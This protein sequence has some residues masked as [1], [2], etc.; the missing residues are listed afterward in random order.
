MSGYYLF[1]MKKTLLKFLLITLTLFCLRTES[2]AQNVIYSDT[3]VVSQSYCPGSSQYD[4]WGTFRAALDTASNQFLKVTV[5]GTFNT[6]GRA[7]TNKY[8]V[9]KIAA[10]LKAGTAASYTCDG[11]TWSVGASSACYSN[12]C[13]TGA[14]SVEL[15]VDGTTCNCVTPGYSFRPGITNSNWGGINTGTCGGATQRM[16]VEF[17][18]ISKPND[19]GVAGLNT[20]N[21]CS[22][23]QDITAKISN[24]G[25]T[26]IDSF[27]VYWSV[28][29][30]LQTPRYISSNLGSGKDTSILL[31]TAFSFTNNTTYKFKFWTSRPNGLVDSV[32]LNDTLATTVNFFGNPP[33][34]TTTS[35]IQCG[36]GRPRLSAT[37]GVSTDTIMWYT[38]PTGGSSIGMGSS[39]LG[40][41]IRATT[42]FYAQA[43]RFAAKSVLSNGLT[44]NISVS[45]NYAAYNGN[46][47]D[48]TPYSPVNI[49][50]M[51]FRIYNFT[52][53]TNYLLYYKAG[54]YNGFENNSTAWTAVNGG[55]GRVFTTGGKNYLKVSAKGLLLN[56]GQSYGFYFTIDP[57]T[58]GGNDIYMQ[59]AVN[60]GNADLSM[61]GGKYSYGLFGASGFGPTYTIDC[62]VFYSKACINNSRTPLVV[63]VK[64][65]PIGADVVKG[66]TFNGQ[67]RVGDMSTPDIATLGKTITYELAPPTGYANADHGS[68]WVVNN[69]VAKTR[70]GAIVPSTDYTVV[71]PSSAGNGSISY[72]PKATYLDSFITFSTNFS[73]LGPHFCDSTVQRTLVVAPT[74]FVNFK[75]P[76]SICL[77]DAILFDN[78]STISSGNASYTWY[79]GD[80]DT[81]DLQAPVHEY[82][83]PGVYQVKLKAKSSPWNVFHD[84]TIQLEV[85]E[86]PAAKFRA[87]NKCQGIAVSFQNQTTVGN[88]ALTYDWDFGDNTAHSTATN[89]THNYTN[90]GGYKVTLKASANGC[91]ATVTKNAY[92]FARPVAN[93]AAPLAPICAKSDVLMPNTS[94]IA[95]GSQGAFWRFGNGSS[96]TQFDGKHAYAA[97]GTYAVKL[98]AVSEFDCKDSITK[99]VVIK[100]TPNPAFAGNQFC[101]KIPT[102]FT[103]ST[104]EELPSPVY[105]WSFSDGVTSTLKNVVKTWPSEGPFSATLKA[106]YSN[107]C[108]ASL[109]KDFEVLIQPKADFDVLDICSGETAA[110]VN[111]SRGD[112]GGIVYN[113]DFGNGTFS[114]L[115]APIRLYTPTATTT[116][117]VALVASYPGACSDTIRKTITVSESP[118]S[119]FTSKDLGL[120]K[121]SFTPTNTTYSKYEWL[122]GEG[123]S[124]SL[125]SPTYQYLYSGNFN[126][127]LR[128]TN[129]AGCSNSITKKA[130]ATTSINNINN[131]NS[132]NIYPNPNAG[133]FTVSNA[134]GSSMKVEIYNVLGEKVYTKTTTEG[135][136][137][138]NLDENAKGIYLVKVTVNGVTSTSKITVTN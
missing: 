123:G 69:V 132:I 17:Q 4:K 135:S 85:G 18:K 126:V 28:N 86:L 1:N 3:F 82:L 124:S 109:T 6:T 110:F 30:N 32:G 44:G 89:P 105:N 39:I 97:S 119:N 35:F 9:R 45:F 75:F 111:K 127:T 122:F 5:K 84:T 72:A 43:I 56:P 23:S 128:T 61:T 107:G 67:F 74:P 103:N 115:Q 31:Q 29:G 42:T 133:S 121:V 63:T 90:P 20:L 27:R 108:S 51:T 19:M 64:P 37:T 58:G 98:L 136:L 70:F 33:A 93:F 112:K 77:G 21:F 10:A 26:K 50:S 73:D 88:G 11:F 106:S 94:T 95:L 8:T 114:T 34:P 78:V 7:C 138:V 47:F 41:S 15:S 16:T 87:N 52:P 118:V 71:A 13:G 79:F 54:S 134:D 60:V 137:A 40:P 113:W 120:L 129:A 99:N 62:E 36:I 65:R 80:G 76:A 55:G 68:T 102:I 116:Y 49:D 14:N 38:G 100:A 104:F 83:S 57:S 131:N 81:S 101:G 59:G 130:V 46:Y 22:N 117:T 12:V 96:S 92:S 25:T 48:L 66:S 53:T 24:F 91:V 125:T 2:K